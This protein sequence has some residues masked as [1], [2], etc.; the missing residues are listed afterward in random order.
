MNIFKPSWRPVNQGVVF[1]VGVVGIEIAL[2]ARWRS[3]RKLCETH[4][5]E[6]HW[7]RTAMGKKE[8]EKAT[9]SDIMQFSEGKPTHD[10]VLLKISNEFLRIFSKVLQRS[11][12]RWWTGTLVIYETSLHPF[13]FPRIKLHGH[14]KIPTKMSSFIRW[15]EKSPR[16]EPT[17]WYP[18]I[19]SYIFREIWWQTCLTAAVS[20]AFTKELLQFHR[21]SGKEISLM[22]GGLRSAPVQG[23]K[24]S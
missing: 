21:H 22:Y 14:W 2:W 20:G 3:W 6:T 10:L 23:S 19:V 5:R 1:M 18:T 9:L 17:G 16:G 4:G 8:L 13:N 7:N 12:L 15:I 24:L 11:L